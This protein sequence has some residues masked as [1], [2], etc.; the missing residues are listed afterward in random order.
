MLHN[1]LEYAMKMGRELRIPT[2]SKEIPSSLFQ[3]QN[4]S[5][6]ERSC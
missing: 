5:R 3:A 6:P 1:K 4:Y 2:E